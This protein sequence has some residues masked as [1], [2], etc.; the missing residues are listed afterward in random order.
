MIKLMSLVEIDVNQFTPKRAVMKGF[1][2]KGHRDD[3]IGDDIVLVK[4]VAIPV[5]KIKPTQSIIYT[6][7]SIEMAYRPF[8]GDELYTIISN[9]NHILDGH[10]RWASNMLKD[11]NTKMAGY[12]IDMN[13]HDLIHVLRAV[14]DAI[15]NPRQGA[16]VASDINIFKAK[17]GDI[18]DI[19]YNGSHLKPGQ[20]KP[21]EFQSWYEGIGRDEMNRRLKLI[22]RNKPLT[23]LDRTEMPV[24]KINQVNFLNKL[25]KTGSVD[26]NAPYA[27]S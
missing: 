7:K 21:A 23:T 2:K 4:K 12:K 19:I 5:H 27:K 26:I 8:E 6:A 22:Q 10:H 18:E 11:P 14:G 20:F 9:D 13:V 1:L 17:I 15:G 24:I 25:L 3:D 16:P